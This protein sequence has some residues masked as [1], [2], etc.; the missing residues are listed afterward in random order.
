M[1]A[2]TGI[3]VVAELTGTL[4]AAIGGVQREHDRRLAALWPP[5]VTLIGS[6]GVGPIVAGVTADELR[7]TLGVVAAR[8]APLSLRFGPP[9]RFLDRDI[10]VVP[11]DP[12]GALR[13]LHEELK[14]SGIRTHQARYPFTPHVTLT[15]YPPLTRE[16]EQRL[17]ALRFDTPVVIDELRVYLTRDPQPAN[18]LLA[19][20][21]TG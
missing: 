18:L 15:M 7:S 11:L 1:P 19:L 9:Y 8:T 14:I 21:L 17:L 10:V 2:P 3:F 5:H 13:K 6:S 20:P 4:A 12:H 16:R